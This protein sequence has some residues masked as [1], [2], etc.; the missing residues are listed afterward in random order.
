MPR[1]FTMTLILLGIVL[2]GCGSDSDVPSANGA[3]VAAEDTDSFGI[4][5]MLTDEQVTTVLAGHDGGEVTHSGGSMMDGVDS[6]QCSYTSEANDQYSVLALVVSVAS[7][8]E[9]LAKLRPSDFLYS[10]DNRPEIADGAFVNDKMDGE[11]GVT[12]IKG[13]H[14]IDL[15]LSSEDAHSR[16]QAL[17]ELA[18]SVAG[19]L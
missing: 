8:P 14:K 12:V 6:Y 15:D 1:Y 10:E 11:L 9:L 18:A 3:A 13:L 16:K 17:L 2:A 4:C 19:K 7:N 5:R